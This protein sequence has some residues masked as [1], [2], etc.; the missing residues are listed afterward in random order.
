[1]GWMT[2]KIGWIEKNRC[3]KES[4]TWL[5]RCSFS[6]H[7]IFLNE[8]TDRINKRIHLSLRK[9][10]K[11]FTIQNGR[12]FIIAAGRERR[13]GRGVRDRNYS[14]M[15][16]GEFGNIN[17]VCHMHRQRGGNKNR[18]YGTDRLYDLLPVGWIRKSRRGRAQAMFL[19]K[20][21]VKLQSR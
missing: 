8:I 13:E 19:K 9:V 4:R 20:S 5:Q 11:I 17:K 15:E 10:D 7:F 2:F 14:C 16:L 3:A 21:Y 18:S 1:M 6:F 12:K